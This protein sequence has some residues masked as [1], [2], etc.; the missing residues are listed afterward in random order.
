MPRWRKLIWPPGWIVNADQAVR[1]AAQELADAGSVSPLPEARTLVAHV[2]GVDPG[3]LMLAPEPTPDQRA[4]ID[5]LLARRMAGE[6]VQHLT[7]EAHFRTVSLQVGPGVFIPRPE[8]E[9]MT[10]WALEWLASRGRARVVELCAGSGAIS[11]ALTSENPDLEIHACEVDPAAVRYAEINLAGTTVD[12]AC[13]D[14]ATAFS[15]LDA[16]VDLVIANPPYI[17]LTAWESVTAEVRDHDPQLALF[18][19]QDG[20]DA[21]RVV[22]G[23]AAR[24]LRPGGVVVAEHAEA[25]AH[26]APDVFVSNGHFQAVRD[27]VDLAG[28]PRFVSAL[29]GRVAGLPG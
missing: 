20:L 12:L 27:H 15:D 21:M 23:V 9:V 29:R 16:T 26:S 6:P 2:L 28:R 4:R 13:A 25:Q 8:T 3:R 5:E 18:S 24:L 14:M 7:G 10:G 19:G 17:P 1:V 11:L 22:A